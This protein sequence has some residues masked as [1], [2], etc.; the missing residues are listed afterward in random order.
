MYKLLVFLV[1]LFLPFLGYTQK[2]INSKSDILI[3]NNAPVYERG[4]SPELVAELTFLDGNNNG[5]LDPAENAE[6]KIVISNVGRGK[7]QGIKINLIHDFD[8]NHVEVNN[9]EEIFF[10]YPHERK[11]VKIPVKSDSDYKRK[12]NT[13]VVEIEEHFGFNP[14]VMRLLLEPVFTRTYTPNLYVDMSFED[15]NNNGVLESFEKGLLKISITNKG[16]GT[17]QGL[18]ISITDNISDSSFYLRKNNFEVFYLH[19]SDTISFIVPIEAG[20]DIQSNE[21]KLTISVSEYYGY[22]MDPAYL[23]LNTL[24]YQQPQL[25]FAGFDI[26]DYGDGTT[27]INEDGQLQPGENVKLK[28]YI[29]NIGLGEAED[30]K[31]TI[32]SSNANVSIQEGDGTIGFLQAGGVA[33]IYSWISPNK[34]VISSDELGIKLNCTERFGEG[35]LSNFLIPIELNQKPPIAKVVKIDV[36]L[37]KLTKKIARFEYTSKKFSTNIGRIVD[38]SL[39]EPTNFKRPHSVAVVIGIEDYKYLP[40]APYASNDADI[41]TSYLKERFGVDKVVLFKNSD[42][43]GFIFDEIFDAS[44]GELQ[45]SIIRGE[46]ELFVFYSGHG[47]PSKDGRDIYLFPSD[48]KT[49]MLEKQGYNI[50]DLYNNLV[51]L[52]AKNTTV[53]IDACFSGVSKVSE[54]I[55]IENLVAQKGV[56]INPKYI[57]PWQTNANFSVFNSS[58]LNE[59]SLGFDPSKTGL[60]TYYVCAGLGGEADFNKDRKITNGELHN[61]V[62]NKVIET[63][64]KI[65]GLQS[66]QFHGNSESIL[67]EY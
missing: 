38:I 20:K 29:Q 15:E 16:N 53:F 9:P 22:D 62:S 3:F 59:T 25:V 64:K 21:H 54:K 40:P 6:V 47:I 30:T 17:A 66:P 55:K 50:N 8:S 37:D 46:T 10:I 39:I 58:G 63:S 49:E 44:N 65:F 34:K 28:L 56:K 32:F 45:K 31:Y 2:T 27:S 14:K 18:K 51:L 57:E 23:V 42:A 26:I 1:I 36:D 33:E 43:V 61:Y 52:G 24:E 35:D 60:F 41:F 7:A 5:I 11:V 67:Y 48:G 12:R 4:E 19:A 13:L